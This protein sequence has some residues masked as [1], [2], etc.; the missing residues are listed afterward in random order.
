MKL[1]NSERKHFKKTAE[2][3]LYSKWVYDALD[4]AETQEE[5][6]R[7]M[8]TARKENTNFWKDRT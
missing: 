5:A 3:L 8:I 6:A 2:Q 7:I 1:T 4:R